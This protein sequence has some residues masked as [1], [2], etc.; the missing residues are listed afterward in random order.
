MSHIAPSSAAVQ[1]EM[2]RLPTSTKGSRQRAG[3]VLQQPVELHDLTLE[4]IVS[5]PFVCAVS[6]S[7]LIVVCSLY[8]S[9][10]H[11]YSRERM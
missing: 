11:H 10:S 9:Y 4:M 2:S 8:F 1:S 7:R 6:T 5:S 3:Q